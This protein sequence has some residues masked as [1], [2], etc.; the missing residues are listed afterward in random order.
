MGGYQELTNKLQRYLNQRFIEDIEDL[1]KEQGNITNIN[2]SSK[3]ELLEE[4]IAQLSSQSNSLNQSLGTLREENVALNSSNSNLEQELSNLQN[5]Y[6]TVESNNLAVQE[7]IKALEKNEKTLYE[8]IE[9]LKASEQ[10]AKDERKVYEEK[11]EIA[12]TAREAEFKK[13]LTAVQQS[14]EEMK[15]K[16]QQLE[17]ADAFNKD[18]QDQLSEKTNS[19]L[20]DISGHLQRIEKRIDGNEERS[21]QNTA[22]VQRNSEKINKLA[23]LQAS[24]T[25]K[26]DSKTTETWNAID[27]VV[28]SHNESV[29]AINE[30]IKINQT[31][32]ENVQFNIDQGV[33]ALKD[34]NKKI[35]ETFQGRLEDTNTKVTL[36]E[37]AHQ[38]QVQ[39]NGHYDTLKSQIVRLDEERQQQE[40]KTR[41]EVD[42]TLNQNNQIINRLN[43]LEGKTDVNTKSLT[44][45][46]SLAKSTDQKIAVFKQE[47]IKETN[48]HFES[49][50]SEVSTTLL[51]VVEKKDDLEKYFDN[52][53]EDSEKEKEKLMNS[54]DEKLGDCSAKI[55]SLEAADVFLQGTYRKMTEKTIEIEKELE[56][57]EKSLKKTNEDMKDEILNK[58]I[59]EKNENEKEKQV[60]SKKITEMDAKISGIE[61]SVKGDLKNSENEIRNKFQEMRTESLNRTNDMETVVSKYHEAL[62]VVQDRNESNE[63]EIKAVSNLANTNCKGI[64]D[65]NEE[66][67]VQ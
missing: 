27:K 13:V 61:E 35:V 10:K 64:S 44:E 39:K 17:K 47:I 29:A 49:M 32:V 1:S 67:A 51:K 42:A 5:K 15:I 3:F 6:F 30:M 53:K 33:E 48:S 41:D 59:D 58:M 62:L 50:K 45:I 66:Q 8:E 28:S 25:D 23:E 34:Q 43:D 20:A 7:K 4:K 55:S 54:V 19:S 11:T 46:E 56:N 63:K 60:F 24:I 40:A 2:I 52:I 31:N 12:F 16:I 38:L 22:G 26:I 18:Y 65:L 21:N 9:K 36:L 14:E 37:E 57:M